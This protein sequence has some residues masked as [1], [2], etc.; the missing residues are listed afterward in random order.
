MEKCRAKGMR[1]LY[2]ECP[3]CGLG[4]S[5]PLREPKRKAVKPRSQ[6]KERELTYHCPTS[7]CTGYVVF[8]EPPIGPFWGCGECGGEWSTRAGV[9][10]DIKR[11]VKRYPYRASVYLEKRGGL[12]PVSVADEPEDYDDLVEQEPVES[13]KHMSDPTQWRKAIGGPAVG[14]GRASAAG[15]KASKG[16]PSKKKESRSR[17]K[18]GEKKRRAKKVGKPS[19]KESTSKKAVKSAT[20]TRQKK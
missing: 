16:Q 10:A 13:P 14:K 17:S 1:D 6:S 5:I 19:Q 9:V 15:K 2:I 4:T 12:Y 11:A 8:V 20:R 7:H 3:N 18:S